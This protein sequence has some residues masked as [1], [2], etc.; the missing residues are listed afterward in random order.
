MTYLNEDEIEELFGLMDYDQDGVISQENFCEVLKYLRDY[1]FPPLS[2]ELE[3]F[4]W[5]LHHLI[6]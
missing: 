6:S 4:F 3:A 2:P 5:E 1:Y